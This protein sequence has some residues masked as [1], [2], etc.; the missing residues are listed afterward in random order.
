M[1][2]LAEFIAGGV[3]IILSYVGYNERDKSKIKQ[4]LRDKMTRSETADLIKDKIE[5]LRVLAQEH[6]EDLK[7]HRAE[8]KEDISRLEKKLDKVIDKR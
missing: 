7:E 2:S 5:P 8:H 1:S 3:A 6:K 4:Q